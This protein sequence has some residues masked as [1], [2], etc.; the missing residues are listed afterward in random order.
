MNW[1]QIMYRWIETAN[2]KVVTGT[3]AN[4]VVENWQ[5]CGIVLNMWSN[6]LISLEIQAQQDMDKKASGLG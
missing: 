2:Y 1:C 6:D 5:G 3:F 4:S